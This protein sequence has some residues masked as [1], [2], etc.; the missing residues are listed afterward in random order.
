MAF[1]IDKAREK[2]DEIE[3]EKNLLLDRLKL[4][5]MEF[6][7]RE[8]RLLQEF[9]EEKKNMLLRGLLDKYNSVFE[10]VMNVLLVTLKE[11]TDD[12]YMPRWF[13]ELVD[14]I[15][16][17]LWPA[18]KD[19]VRGQ[20]LIGVE[21]HRVFA[22]GEKP[23][24][25]LI[26]PFFRYQ[27]YPYDRNA[28]RLI[29][30]PIWWFCFVLS[31]CP[32]YSISQFYYCLIF[33][34]IDK[35]DQFQLENFIMEFKC[36]Q[37]IGLGIISAVIGSGQYYVCTTREPSTCDTVAPKVEIY[38]IIMF[39]VQVIFVWIAFGLAR[40]S[41]K[42]GGHYYQHSQVTERDLSTKQQ[43]RDG[44][45]NVLRGEAVAHMAKD[46]AELDAEVDRMCQRRLT[47]LLIYDAVTFAICIG[48]AIWATWFSLLDENAQ[49][50]ENPDGAGPKNWKFNGTLFW[51]RAL[52]G[53]LSFPFIL[54]RVPGIS[55]AFS[56]AKPTG[57]NPY[58][59]TVPYL[60]TEEDGP[61]PWDPERPFKDPE[62]QA[63]H[64][65]H[66][67]RSNEPIAVV[68]QR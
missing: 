59:K 56:H 28:W 2:L 50:D 61:V 13:K 35:R 10:Y 66:R 31:I 18:A 58:G 15:I 32:Y 21:E 29:R 64:D 6:K 67:A 4:Q 39:V 26:R 42:K 40:C 37:F 20:V 55:A 63:H 23:C 44:F 52:Y 46:T 25:P 43:K 53:L 36:F 34:L 9:A 19:A 41:H 7:A 22:H 11:E 14:T 54:L 12:P 3:R 60:G 27:L 47:C 17:S 57:Y 1:L 45:L 5:A 48:L 24:C 65:K 16:D 68:V 62:D 51:I 33:L 49:V 8:E 38:V 30:N